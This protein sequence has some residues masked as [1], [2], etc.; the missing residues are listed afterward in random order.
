MHRQ[1]GPFPPH[2]PERSIKD[3]NEAKAARRAE[4]E[5]RCSLFDPPLPPNLLNHME[6]FQAAI[7]IPTA[8][9]EPA[10]DILKPRLLSQREYAEKREQEQ[11]QQNELL[12]VEY[13]QRRQQEAQLKETKESFDRHW[14]SVQTPIRERLGALADEIIEDQWA[15]GRLITKDTSP[16]FAS[17]VLIHVRRRFYEDV[18]HENEI[19]SSAGQPIQ[20]DP[21]NGPP[22]RKLILENMKWLFDTKIKPLTEHFQKE[23]FLCN[24]CDENFK[25]YGFEGVIQHY[26]AKHTTALSMGSIIVYWRA[27]WPEIPPFNPDPSIS[28][29]AYYKIPTPTTFPGSYPGGEQQPLSSYGRVHSSVD[30]NSGL[31]SYNTSQPS[32][33]TH[34]GASTEQPQNG[35]YSFSHHQ[36]HPAAPVQAAQPSTFT[37]GPLQGVAAQH[38]EPIGTSPHNQGPTSHNHFV[39]YSNYGYPIASHPPTGAPAPPQSQFNIRH[40]TSH[41]PHFDPSRNN[42][43]QFTELYREQMEE[44]AKHAREVWFGTSGIKDLPQSVRIYVVIHHMAARFATRFANVPSLAM[45]LDGLD[46]NAQMRPVRSLNGL[47]CKTCVTQLKTTSGSFPQSQPPTGDRRL[48]TLP[49]LLNHF[50]TAH[51]EAPQAFASPNTGPDGPRYDWTQ[52]MIEL[53]EMQLITN[54]ISASGMDDGKLELIAWAFPQAFPSP[55]PKLGAWRSSGPVPPSREASSRRKGHL[56]HGAYD[57]VSA[58]SP[59]TEDRVDQQPYARPFSGFGSSSQPSRASEPPGEDE[60]DPHKP[61]YMGKS[62]KSG[63]DEVAGSRGIRS[64]GVARRLYELPQSHGGSPM[65]ETTDLS[66]LIY[67]ATQVHPTYNKETPA[68][69]SYEQVKH[70]HQPAGQNG[71]M[72]DRNGRYEP[73][74]RQIQ[75]EEAASR[76]PLRLNAF[77]DVVDGQN[78]RPTQPPREDAMAAERFLRTLGQASTSEGAAQE[79]NSGHSERLATYGDDVRWSGESVGSSLKNQRGDPTPLESKSYDIPHEAPQASPGRHART[80]RLVPTNEQDAGQLQSRQAEG[81]FYDANYRGAS[82]NARISVDEFGRTARPYIEYSTPGPKLIRDD[83]HVEERDYL[84]FPRSRGLS[85]VSQ[86]GRYRN[87]SRSPPET[88]YYRPRTP[89]DVIRQQ[90][91][92]QIRSPLQ[93]KES[94]SQRVLYQ[95]HLQDRYAYV[96]DNVYPPDQYR[97]RIEYVPVR[98][99]HQGASEPNRYVIAQPM[100]DRERPEYVRLGGYDPEPVYERDGQLYRAET[101]KYPTQPDREIA[102]FRASYPY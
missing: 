48:Y 3:V 99:G 96:D 13:T 37:H 22:T 18:T 40:V 31:N 9:T 63:P 49:L 59:A 21:P 76:F 7:Q 16:K 102:G 15:G 27:E 10:W 78:S 33:G 62:V 44:M 36:I 82:S 50:R 87:R 35:P 77:D 1:A 12:Q 93:L 34:T 91:S 72:E 71:D 70:Y 80:A 11:I 65:A 51:L 17:D 46:N 88:P 60:Y 29:S 100:A 30:V 19:L 69:R 94:R 68:A 25:F 66:R 8:L 53:P 89:A 55:L 47:A 28:K 24:G 95:P 5:R 61:A 83:Q 26:A 42:A 97:Q 6:S 32:L 52:D 79:G 75:S 39:H 85:Q 90:T 14:D 84:E 23:L 2:R 38:Q 101:R 56:Q 74:D 4:I 64:P 92:Y 67:S 98:V 73:Y 45:F 43:A 58:N 57:T 54:L 81:H 41:P 86:V 20:S